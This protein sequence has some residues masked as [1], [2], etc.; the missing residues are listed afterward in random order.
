[1]FLDL[2]GIVDNDVLPTT[3]QPGRFMKGDVA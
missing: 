1:M 3:S 2:V